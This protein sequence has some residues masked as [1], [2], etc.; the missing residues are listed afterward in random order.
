MIKIEDPG[1]NI[2]LLDICMACAINLRTELK[3]AINAKY[4]SKAT[5]TELFCSHC[6]NVFHAEDQVVTQGQKCLRCG[7]G[8]LEKE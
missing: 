7:E 6:A 5:E 3:K 4:G 8:T 1:I 2:H